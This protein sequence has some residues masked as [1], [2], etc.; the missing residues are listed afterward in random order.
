MRSRFHLMRRSALLALVCAVSAGCSRCGSSATRA[1]G[2]AADN[3]EASSAIA[4]KDAAPNALD[5]LLHC[6]DARLGVSSK[7]QNPRDFAEHITDGK[8]DTAWNG[9]TG[10]RG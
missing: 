7:V 2:A 4:T 6:T 5:D 8:L 3:L 9:K 1:A 10:G